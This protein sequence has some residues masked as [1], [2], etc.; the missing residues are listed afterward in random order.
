MKTDI[1]VLAFAGAAAA[2][3]LASNPGGAVP[4]GV[5]APSTK[6]FQN[7]TIQPSRGGAA[8]CVS[9]MIP[10]RASTMKN[11]K[12][13]YTLPVNQTQVTET[14]VDFITAGSPFMESIMAG[15]QNISGTFNIGATLCTPAN[16]TKPAGVQLLTHG[17]GFDRHYW[18][19]GPGYSY[20]DVAAENGYASFFYDRLGVGKSN[21]S[22]PLN[23]VQ[24]PMEVEIARELGIMLRNGSFAQTNFSSVIGVGHSFGSIISQAVTS[25]YPAVFDAAILTGFS[26]NQT[27]V[28]AFISAANLQIASQ[29]SPYRFSDPAINAGYL[30]TATAIGNQIQ[31]FR[32]PNFDPLV[33]AEADANKGTVTIGEFFSLSAVT[34][35]AKNFTGPVAVVNGDNDLP[36]CFGNCSYPTNQAAAVFPVLYPSLGSN[37]NGSLLV[38]TTGHGINLHYSAV[39]AYDWIQSFIKSHN[40]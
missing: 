32:A 11:L 38:P 40:L 9:G 7:A 1:T 6:G 28:P 13:N 27:A 37:M 25:M 18:D 33:L 34:A 26:L 16:N 21:K 36:F 23:V 4:M 5:Q 10:V 3:G 30:V 29:N 22:D 14:F 8:V 24:A 19:F 31:F 35:P 17:I 15:T 20:V 12:F 2:Q 39:S